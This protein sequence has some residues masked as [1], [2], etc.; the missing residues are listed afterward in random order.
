MR[1]KPYPLYD[2]PQI[3]DLKEMIRKRAEEEPEAIAFSYSS[4]KNEV[5]NKTSA[6]FSC[7]IDALG[8]YLFSLGL[9]GKHI[10][11]LGENSYEWIVAFCAIVNGGGVAVPIDKEQPLEIVQEL[12]RQSDCSAVI[13][14]C[15][16]KI[17]LIIAIL[18]GFL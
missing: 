15:T 10:A 14:S 16:T 9:Q 18:K 3:K 5:I 8:T 7:D 6:E 1:N 4:G 2:N 13:Y 17:S 12:L 11:I